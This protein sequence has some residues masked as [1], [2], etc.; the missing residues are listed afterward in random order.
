MLNIRIKKSVQIS[1]F[2]D[3]II[4]GYELVGGGGIDG[5]DTDY[6][7]LL[8]QKIDI[9]TKVEWVADTKGWHGGGMIEEHH[10]QLDQKVRYKGEMWKIIKLSETGLNYTCFL[11]GCQDGRKVT[12]HAF[13]WI[14]DKENKKE[15]H[16]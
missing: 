2:D 6:H 3:I 9:P 7:T 5:D 1:H 15:T 14:L 4:D 8:F 16:L 12:T 11:E 10:Y 13:E